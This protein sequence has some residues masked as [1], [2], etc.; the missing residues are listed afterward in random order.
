MVGL[1]WRSGVEARLVCPLSQW[2][3]S[4]LHR[5]D[6]ELRLDRDQDWSGD[7]VKVG[8]DSVREGGDVVSQ[9]I[10]VLA[11]IIG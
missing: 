10:T 1:Q 4:G 8:R 5:Q 9:D 2:R 11:D 3:R 6:C 7:G